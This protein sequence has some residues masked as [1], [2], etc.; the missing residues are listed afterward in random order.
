MT[1]CCVLK[2]NITKK[3]AEVV[4]DDWWEWSSSNGNFFY[5]EIETESDD[6]SW[7]YL[8]AKCLTDEGVNFDDEEV[9]IYAD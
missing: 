5:A 2:K 7:F 4:E 1:S 3:I 6:N 8:L 9:F